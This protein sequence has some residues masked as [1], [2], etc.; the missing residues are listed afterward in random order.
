MKKFSQLI[1][2]LPCESLEEFPVHGSRGDARSLLA[3]WTGLW[4]P[5]LIADSGAGPQ[6]RTASDTVSSE[7]EAEQHR[8]NFIQQH[9]Y[10]DDGTAS[11]DSQVDLDFDPEVFQA[12]WGESLVVIPE[13]AIGKVFDGFKAAASGVGA[14]VV[15]VM[16]A[17]QDAS[18]NDVSSRA[19]WLRELGVDSS[20]DAELVEDFF[21]LGYVRLQVEM[22]TRKLRYSSELDCDRFDQ[23]VVEAA[24]AASQND[25][26]TCKQ[27]LQSAFDQLSEEKNRY[28]PVAA[29]FVDMV[30]VA[31]S[32]RQESIDAELNSDSPK[33]F[34]MTGAAM[35]QL[36]EKSPETASRMKTK[37][38]DESLCIVCGPEYELPDNVLAIESILNQVVR[39][40]ES[41][42]VSVG[43]PAKVFM[44]R[45]FGLNVALPGMLENLGFSGAIH[46]T[47]DQG[48]IPSSF[49]NSMRWMGVDGGAVLAVGQVPLDAANDKSF[50]DL[51]VRI[52]SELDSAHVSTVFFARWPTQT[53]DSFQDLRN[54]TK[55]GSVLGDFSDAETYFENVYDP[56][57]GDSY[58]ADE[59]E[60]PWFSQSIASGSSRPISMIVEYWKHW[61]HLAAIRNLAS[62]TKL[63]SS[64]PAVDAETLMELQNRVEL[65]TRK[66]DSDPDDS[67]E[68]DLAKLTSQL[69]SK[70]N[71][72][73]VNSVPWRRIAYLALESKGSPGEMHDND[74]PIK[75]ASRDSKR[76][77]AIVA[78][79]GFAKLPSDIN[80]MIDSSNPV[81]VRE[82]PLVDD[83][84]SILRNELFEVR[85][86]RESG[87]IRGVHF[88]GKR[89]NLFSQRI[90]VRSV[91]SNSKEVVYSKME[92]D[93]FEVMTLSR[94]ASQIK[95]SGR[96][97]GPDEEVLG[98]FVQ[99]V[100]LQRGRNVIDVEIELSDI[101]PLDGSV[102][103]YVANRIAWS[104]D[105]AEL[106]CDI[107][108]GRH[109]VRRPSIEAP[110]FVEVVQDENRFALL[111][112]G[113]PWHRRASK[114]MLDSILVAGKESRRKFR[115]GIAV[116]AD[117]VMQLAVSEMHPILTGT[118]GEASADGANWLFH[119]ANRNVIVTW[120]SAVF[121]DDCR[122]TGMRVRLQETDGRGGDVKLYCR[123]IV[124]SVRIESFSDQ[125][126]RD[127]STNGDDN[128]SESF[129]VVEV[130]IAAHEFL[131]IHLRWAE[132]D[133][134][135]EADEG[136]Q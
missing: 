51:G 113:L 100:G 1:L 29:D 133:S 30:L 19:G 42:E 117:A 121:D 128:S 26:E 118:G 12:R 77:D 66:W 46:A 63:D 56:G 127:I 25:V 61:Y 95:T 104:E 60:S 102:K 130:P 85:M 57:Y 105:T 80:A 36:A 68:T 21:A 14:S 40:R 99:T 82:G 78:L 67:I 124:D 92:C 2:L 76:C 54:A 126:I 31:E 22:M 131:Q 20:I 53:C 73:Y 69:M 115:F 33:S 125:L 55:Y 75:H 41:C 9:Y 90:A 123:K 28:Y 70:L 15:H 88:Y 116:N 48:K 8:Q 86:D 136:K 43:S 35:R 7:Q 129:S 58:E 89:G 45:R 32:N 79:S 96:L 103:N 16:S 122:C 81:A 52:G 134:T 62:L 109:P 5:G 91:D 98:N 24:V 120:T 132:T 93:S 38:E 11:F 72:Q 108:G 111:T 6:W 64:E 13:P 44:R 87:G 34:V 135:N 106:Y 50:L 23:V 49:S 97:L 112:H 107:Q 65:Q 71:C 3:A 37:I 59:Y 101:R 27:K 18:G 94:I 10:D 39:G 114:K 110:H 74:G 17:D 84:E 4:H 119:L 83:G 47:L